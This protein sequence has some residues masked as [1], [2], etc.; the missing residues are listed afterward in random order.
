M[1]HARLKFE[2]THTVAQELAVEPAR[3]MP[4]PRMV[5]QR[6]GHNQSHVHSAARGAAKCFAKTPRGNEVRAHDPRAFVCPGNPAG[7]GIRE[8]RAIP[9]LTQ[10]NAPPCPFAWKRINRGRR[11]C[12]LSPA[13]SP[14]S[15]KRLLPIG[16]DRTVYFDYQVT[17]GPSWRTRNTEL[18]SEPDAPH[19]CNLAVD[20]HELPM[21]TE[22]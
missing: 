7:Y 17:P 4:Y 14:C 15:S 19:E 20:E 11:Q 6:A 21:I 3:G 10:H 1:Q 18:V 22:E 5:G 8:L 9:G 12:Q 13:A 2:D 16:D